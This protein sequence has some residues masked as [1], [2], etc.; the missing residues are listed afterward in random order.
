[1]VIPG[2]KADMAS[3]MPKNSSS[4]ASLAA[5]QFGDGVLRWSATSGR[6]EFV[7][8]NS[9]GAGITLY[10]AIGKINPNE[11]D[12]EIQSIHTSYPA[13]ST[14]DWSPSVPGLIAVGTKEGTVSLLRIDD[15]SN[16]SIAL[17]LKLGRSCLT[18]SF[19]T[20]GLL[21]V[22]LDRIRNDQCLQVW[23]INQRLSGWD[24]SKDGWQF[25]STSHSIVE[26][27]PLYK[28]EANVPVTSARFFEDS[29]QVVVAGIRNTRISI[30]D[31][32]GMFEP[33]VPLLV[34]YFTG[35]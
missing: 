10:K 34:P 26:Q 16:A 7:A 24:S 20:T 25:S 12:F 21:A 18:V 27:T 28:M 2:N 17:P 14:Y 33:I 30:H 29:P 1:M 9:A 11:F 13:F 6:H 15:N 8:L 32:R 22:G 23:D 31:L 19:N 35:R 5:M 3:K 4:L